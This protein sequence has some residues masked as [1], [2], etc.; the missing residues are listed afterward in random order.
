MSNSEVVRGRGRAL[1]WLG[2]ALPLLAIAI[3]AGQLYVKHFRPPWF[4]PVAATVGVILVVAALGRY[5]SFGRFAV[6]LFTVLLA[7][8]AWAFLIM[9]RLPQYDGPVAAGRAFPEFASAKSD[10]APF[11]RRDLIGDQHTLLIFFRG[12]W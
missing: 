12:R 4:L 10:G 2:L 8:A 6:L 1:L 3:Y 9:A 5:R 7:A 11:S